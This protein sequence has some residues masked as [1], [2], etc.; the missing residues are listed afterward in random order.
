[1][2]YITPFIKWLLTCPYVRKNKVFA[3][4]M[5]ASKDNIEIVTQQISRSQDKCYI[6]GSVLHRVVFTVFDYKS[7]SFNQL[8]KTMV[9]KNEN[10]AN[11][12]ETRKLIDWIAEQ[13]KNG[14]YPDFG[15][16]CVVQDVYTEYSSPS[17]PSVDNTTT[18]AIARYSLPV[19]C[20]VLD[21][22]S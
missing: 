8:V 12:L 9:D 22:G 21:Y 1:M 16:N 13:R 7:I 17:T 6:D 15:R 3:N 10:V 14:K 5:Q 18:P 2:D 11:L 20:E 19:I 4:A